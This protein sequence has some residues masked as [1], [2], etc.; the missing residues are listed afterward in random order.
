L[1]PDPLEAVVVELATAWAADQIVDALLRSLG[2][3][4]R[5]GLTAMEVLIDC[6]AARA[7]LLVLDNCEHVAVEVGRVVDSL[8]AGTPGVRVLATSREPLGLAGEAVFQLGPLSLPD[9][10]GDVG[11]IVRS[12]AGRF[13]V[14]RAATVNRG[15]ALTPAAARAIAR[16]CAELDGLPL[17]LGLAAARVEHM[18]PREIADGLARRG[19]LSGPS[20]DSSVP[21]HRSVRA[22]LDWSYGLLTEEERLLVRH[23][24][25]FVG[26][27]T[28]EAA[29]AVGLPEASE[30][31]VR[32]LLDGLS[33]KGV[34]M[35]LPARGHER[36]SF[37][38]T[39]GE[40]ASEHFA[41]DD[42]VEAV[43]DRHMRWFAACAAE[44]D[45]LLLER[46]GQDL[47]D[48]E[49]PNMRLALVRALERDVS[50]ALGVVA[51]LTRHWILAEHF[52]EGRAATD[53]AL[54][55]A[56]AESDSSAR[57]VVLCGAGMIRA[58]S[59]DYQAAVENT[60]AGLA[61][62]AGIGDRS[63]QARCLQLSGMVLIL[64][65]LD[66]D[67]GLRSAERAVDLLRATGD[68]L[69]LA[70]AVVNVAMAAGLCD[71]FDAARA[72]YGEF[73]SIPGAPEQPRLRTWVELAAAWAEL[74]VGS[75][76]RALEHADCA[77]ELEGDRSSMNYF[78]AT[79]HRVHAL[80]LLGRTQD[81]LELGVKS[82]ARAQESGALMAV[83]AI[84]MALAIA[85]M[86]HGDL[87]AAAAR[88][89]PLVQM[90]QLHTAAL[91][92]EVL[93]RA[94]LACGDS[95]EAA[96]QAREL[97]VIAERAG[98]ARH[99]A[100]ADLLRGRAAALDGEPD[101]ARALLHDALRTYA[102][103]G[104]ERGAADALQE[105]GLLAAAA[106]DGPRA[107][108]LA[109]AA[110]AA[111]ARLSCRPL[112]A[113]TE[114]LE[115][116]RAR[117]AASN[118]AASWDEAWAQG[119]K[120]ALVDAIAY[121]QRGRGRRDRPAVGWPSLTPAEREVA[122]LA[123]NGMSNP[124][125]AAQLFVSRSTVKMHLSNVYL[126]LR[127]ANRTELARTIA[128]S[129]ERADTDEPSGWPLVRDRSPR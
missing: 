127:V 79:C 3:R 12:D 128:T 107:A 119:E 44:V 37:L 26:G 17:A 129:S 97:D 102:D 82:L 25:C 20:S 100:L 4:E 34:I 18:T 89:R 67:H 31:R 87:E 6:V 39:V 23:L 122:D 13:F 55:A 41:L 32:D 57:A 2:A 103:L 70:W 81:A 77:R 85:E 49:T 51:S 33:R 69:G 65:G 116:A 53:A 115:A 21:Q 46:S 91:M 123:A 75:A 54:S 106:E 59:E 66:V 93:G 19:R 88:A 24:S 111:R 16:I 109:A 1:G 72:A 58:L 48:D 105:L 112:V 36:W 7:V 27:W 28:V 15:F 8:I 45:E 56:E 118:G 40:Y 62:L 126:K 76:Q 114:R 117:F 80:A 30:A 9:A 64:T 10:E 47:L 96:V 94:A 92:R 68:Q 120:L 104:L 29:R 125:I 110:S 90:P 71:Q 60:Q 14:D 121:A 61:L 101:E 52:E 98:S 50:V 5:G 74:I 42:D 11:A 113:D 73:L 43:R 84:E 35:G 124:Q 95:S 83:P 78:V 99:H 108:R 38:Q 22:S 86:A 63:R